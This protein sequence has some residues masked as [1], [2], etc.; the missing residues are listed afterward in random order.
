M[1]RSFQEDRQVRPLQTDDPILRMYTCEREESSKVNTE[2][3]SL[4]LVSSLVT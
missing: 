2:Q 3:C 1:T 4:E